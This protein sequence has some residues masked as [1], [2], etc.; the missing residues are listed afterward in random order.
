M[1]LKIR[2]QCKMSVEMS[3][4]ELGRES[5][6]GAEKLSLI[7]FDGDR[8]IS[9]RLGDEARGLRPARGLLE[10]RRDRAPATRHILQ[11]EFEVYGKPKFERL[12]R[13]SNGR[14]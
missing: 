4:E 6:L 2:F 7:R 1:S 12:A 9:F 10:D 11:P 3:V 8:G 13:I 5:V 14:L